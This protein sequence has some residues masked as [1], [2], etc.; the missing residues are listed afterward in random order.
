MSV[1]VDLAT[2]GFA[3][4]ITLTGDGATFDVHTKG[5]EQSVAIPRNDAERVLKELGIASGE[6][7]WKHVVL[8]FTS[9]GELRMRVKKVFGIKKNPKTLAPGEDPFAWL[10]LKARKQI[11][12]ARVQELRAEIQGLEAKLYP[13][14]N[15]LKA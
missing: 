14:E 1:V 4:A 2:A 7:V 12:D 6:P 3:F 9:D 8:D 11:Y 5:S 15:L 10:D 13:L